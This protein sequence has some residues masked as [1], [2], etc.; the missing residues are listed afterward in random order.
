MR[1]FLGPAIALVAAA[2]LAAPS[3]GSSN[4]AGPTSHVV[5]ARCAADKDCAKRCLLG[6]RFPNGYCSQ[7][8]MTDKD[9][10]GGAACVKNDA[11]AGV[12]MATCQVPADCNGYGT[13]YECNRVARQA[14]GEEGA[15]V[16]TGG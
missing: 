2:W 14:A 16:C 7:T 4:D 15:L 5:G 3:C 1:T 12:C 8:C 13:G 6:S 9:C 10:P 11:T